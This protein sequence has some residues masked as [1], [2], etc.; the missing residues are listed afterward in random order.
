MMWSNKMDISR[1]PSKIEE[2]RCSIDREKKKR[3][4]SIPENN[5]IVGMIG[6]VHPAVLKNWKLE[7]PVAAFEIDL[8]LI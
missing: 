7:M 8:S 3:E 6:E 4:L 2:K 5:K 1:R